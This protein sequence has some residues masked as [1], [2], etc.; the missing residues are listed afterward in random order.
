VTEFE[1]ESR[2]AFTGGDRRRLAAALSQATEV[3]H[4][5]RLQAV[6]QV[7]EGVSVS[8]VA[9]R[10]KVDRSTVHRWVQTYGQTRQPACLAEA[11]RAGR[12]REASDL[13]EELLAELLAH[14]PR[15][16]GYRATSWTAPL[17]RRHLQEECGC[18]VSERTLRRRLHEYGWNWKRLRYVYGQRASQISQKKGA[19][20][21]V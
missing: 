14:D 16:L 20:A 11:P 2:F 21:G 17:L 13:D 3:R 1:H 8:A 12:P 18:P 7:A 9:Q 4:F 6:L 5:R 19:F 10:A 15:S